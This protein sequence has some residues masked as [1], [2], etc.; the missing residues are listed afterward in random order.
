MS[1][2]T[3]E[4]LL[5]GS[6][7]ASAARGTSTRNEGT[8]AGSEAASTRG[9]LSRSGA[10]RRDGVA[11]V[12][13]QALGADKVWSLLDAAPD[14][15]LIY[16]EVGRL[17]WASRALRTLFGWDPS[18][19][20]GQPFY[21][22]QPAESHESPWKRWCGVSTPTWVQRG[23]AP[24]KDG[25]MCWV[26]EAISV[27]RDPDGAVTAAV[28]S[29]RDITAQV[30]AMESLAESEAFF[31]TLAECA[32][33][34]TY[35]AD[36]RG[37]FTWLS[38]GASNALGVPGES[39]IGSPLH[40]WLDPAD[41]PHWERAVATARSG[42]PAEVRVRLRRADGTRNWWAITL[43][44]SSNTGAQVDSIA[45]A[46]REIDAEVRREEALLH[47]E[48]LY[49]SLVEGAG[50]LTLQVGH[51]TRIRWASGS[52]QALFGYQQNDLI[53]SRLAELIELDGDS[54]VASV[55]EKGERAALAAWV[56]TSAGHKVPVHVV[57]HPRTTADSVTWVV[58]AHVLP[59]GAERDLG[60]IQPSVRAT[61]RLRGG[62]IQWVS[63]NITT[64]LGWTPADLIG[65]QMLDFVHSGD[66]SAVRN[67]VA[68]E[69]PDICEDIQCRLQ[70]FHGA[71][72]AMRLSTTRI[73]R[74][75]GR[76]TQVVA[77]LSP[78]PNQD[79]SREG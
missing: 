7:A 41:H 15:V 29:A 40:R 47:S 49:Y 1:T 51:D 76:D 71:Y 8:H 70:A 68:D 22:V 65:G 18:E 9:V 33:E 79:L 37:V 13:P 20:V 69:G 17:R 53:G 31:R 55:W 57:F 28:V 3:L 78:D 25:R 63:P 26:E 61:M 52:V 32:A 56:V 34:V 72:H 24:R 64:L 75:D 44:P 43:T 77:F 16:D 19:V 38:D 27:L 5:A 10:D 30:H 21:L 60:R 45:G 39:L 67:L 12:H 62:V 42:Q 74:A 11:P 50:D 48:D 14:A 4:D 35:Q 66:G 2:P 6:I 54:G 73:R 23:K 46:W 36:T 59:T 58:N